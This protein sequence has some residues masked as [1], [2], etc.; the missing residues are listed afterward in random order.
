MQLFCICSSHWLAA[1]SLLT[2]L[3][4][5][6]PESQLTMCSSL[7]LLLPSHTARTHLGASLDGFNFVPTGIF[8]M[9]TSANGTTSPQCSAPVRLKHAEC[10]S[11]KVLNLVSVHAQYL[12]G[13][14]NKHLPQ[15]NCDVR[16]FSTSLLMVRIMPANV[17]F[18]PS[19]RPF[20]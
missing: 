10:P 9:T 8:A 17:L 1:A 19:T 2:V 14:G 3:V 5:Q 13:H 16:F 6:T 7:K 12:T 4:L 18:M 15:S 11:C 20:D